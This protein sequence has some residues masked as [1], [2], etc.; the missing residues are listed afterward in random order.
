MSLS[1][2]ELS[3]LRGIYNQVKPDLNVAHVEKKWQRTTNSDILIVDGHNTFMRAWCAMPSMN[4]NGDHNGGIIG[5]LRSIGSAIKLYHPTRCIITFDGIGG[6]FQRRKMFPGYKQG[7]KSK[8]R[9]NR[10]Y[11]TDE[12]L[13]EEEKNCARQLARLMDY[14]V[15]LPVNVI[16]LDHVEADDTMAYCALDT[17]KD[18]R[19][20]IMSSDKD[21]LQLVDERIKVWSP[22]K[23]ILYGPA[24]VM[25][26]YGIHPNNFVLF[27]ALDGDKSDGID[28]IKG[29][30]IKTAVKCF[31]FL[32]ESKVYS[33]DDMITHAM[34]LK[35]K[36][37]LHET[38]VENREI[39]ERN[40][41]LMQLKDSLLKTVVQLKVNEDL[42]MKNIPHMNRNGF[43][44]LIVED[45]MSSNFPDHQSWLTEVFA[46]MDSVTR[47]E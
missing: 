36:F 29:A 47:S 9:L 3:T 17:F 11:Q 10:A 1:S 39:V 15:F 2:S 41:S 19:C 18:S 43:V 33:G 32:S 35:K 8:T 22:T 21:F 13:A 30:G 44:R 46:A 5:F 25:R 45:C 38:V 31:P 27:R 34:S 42:E 37:K 26:D 16:L 7:R 20:I 40:I 24:E 6:S 14:L 28:G 4:S 23:K 12:T